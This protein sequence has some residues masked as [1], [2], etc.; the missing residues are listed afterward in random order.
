MFTHCD[1]MSFINYSGQNGYQYIRRKWIV[2]YFENAERGHRTFSFG[3][4]DFVDASS[5]RNIILR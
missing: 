5:E 1:L 3:L 2:E 4:L